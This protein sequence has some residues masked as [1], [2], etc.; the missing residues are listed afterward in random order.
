MSRILAF[1]RRDSKAL[2]VLLLIVSLGFLLRMANVADSPYLVNGIDGPYYVSQVNHLYETGESLHKD[3]PLAFYYLL[4]WRYLLGDTIRALKIGMSVVTALICVP[5]YLLVRQI[6]RNR[7]AAVFSAFL[8]VFNPYLFSITYNLYKNEI[9]I[10]L[11]LVFFV[12]FFRFISTDGLRGKWKEV[13]LLAIVFVAIWTT[14]IMATGMTVL[15]TASYL[16]VALFRERA[17]AIRVLRLLAV[18]GAVGGCALVVLAALFPASFYKVSK[19]NFLT[20]LFGDE[21]DAPK[22]SP[23]EDREG[24][25]Y[26]RF[27]VTNLDPVKWFG[28]PALIG[29]WYVIHRTWRGDNLPGEIFIVSTYFSWL[30]FVQPSISRDLVWRFALVSFVPISLAAGHGL[31]VIRRKV[32]HLVALPLIILVLGMSFVEA[33][34]VARRSRTTVTEAEYMEL[35]EMRRVLPEDFAIVG[36]GGNAY[37]Y[38]VVLDQKIVRSHYVEEETYAT[39]SLVVIESKRSPPPWRGGPEPGPGPELPQPPEPAWLR[40]ARVVWDGRFYRTYLI[41]PRST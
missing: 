37:W 19:L 3:S 2:L 40:R 25:P 39:V 23:Q 10:L 35:L 32:P 5:V 6:T 7:A 15:F 26:I 29:I 20:D 36:L 41:P 16:L 30:V 18:V 13:T 34:V 31:G 22:F 8:S 21:A 1:V 14:H 11:M 24:N 17:A 27:L 33:S 12:L 9:G 4:V 38:E 28:F